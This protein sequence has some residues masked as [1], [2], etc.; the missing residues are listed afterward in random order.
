MND[1]NNNSKDNNINNN[2]NDNNNLDND[3]NLTSLIL[4]HNVFYITLKR[5]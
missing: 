2:Y 4:L 3:N 5:I 1:N